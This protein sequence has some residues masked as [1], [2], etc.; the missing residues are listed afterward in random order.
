MAGALTAPAGVLIESAAPFWKKR[1]LS[2]ISLAALAGQLNSPF[3]IQ[4]APGRTILV[5]L[6]EVKARPERPLKPGRRPPPDAGYEKFSLFFS[7]S[8]ADL[9]P[10]NVYSVEHE[11]LGRFDLFLVPVCTRDPAKIDYQVVVSRPQ[12]R[13]FQSNT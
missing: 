13:A 7:G 8:R 4:A 5:T 9:A 3:R 11:T 2:D 1:S 6:A 12:N 10:Q